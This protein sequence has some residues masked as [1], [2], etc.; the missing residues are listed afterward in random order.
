LVQ[1]SF[2]VM[3]AHLNEMSPSAVRGTFPGFALQFGN[4]LAAGNA[5]VQS[6][7]ADSLHKNYGVALSLVAGLGAIAFCL[8]AYFGP[9][10]R[11]AKMGDEATPIATATVA[12]G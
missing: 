10:A 5:T 3:P 12:R 9:D 11:N 1:C 4:M 7:L 6:M 2:G 8:L